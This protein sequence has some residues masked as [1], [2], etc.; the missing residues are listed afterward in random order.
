MIEKAEVI[1][2]WAGDGASFETAMEPLL[3]SRYAPVFDR[4]GPAPVVTEPGYLMCKDITNQ[5]NFIPDPPALVVLI[6]AETEVMDRIESDDDMI[7]LPG[8]RGE[9]DDS[10]N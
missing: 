4:T 5:Q 3:I 6:T 7:L 9:A 1:T 8:T 2:P 10:I